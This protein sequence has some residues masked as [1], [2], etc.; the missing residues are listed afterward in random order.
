MNLYRFIWTVLKKTET[1]ETGFGET[2]PG[3]E[4]EISERM[5]NKLEVYALEMMAIWWKW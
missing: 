5:S 4:I 1:E 3:K 2:I